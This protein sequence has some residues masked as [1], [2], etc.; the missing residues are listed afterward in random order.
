[1]S[2]LDLTTVNGVR[3]YLSSHEHLV[4]T[5]ILPLS[6]GTA[7]YAYRLNLE[8][9]YQGQL[10][11]VLKY[12]APYIPNHIDFAFDVIRQKYEVEALNLVRSWVSNAA[13]VNVPEVYHFDE[14]SGV[15][16][17]ED[18]GPSSKTLKEWVIQGELTTSL[19]EKLSRGLG[20]FLALIHERGTPEQ[21]SRFASNEQARSISIWATYGRLLSTLSGADGLP[22]LQEPPLEIDEETLE[23]VSDIVTK[24]STKLEVAQSQFV[25]GDFWPGNVLID[26]DEN[27]QIKKVLVVDWELAKAGIRGTDIGQ[28]CAELHLLRH[29]YPERK[30]ISTVLLKNFVDSY[31][32]KSPLG[33]DFREA[34]VHIGAHLI[35]WAP[36]VPWGPKREI[37]AVVVEG[38]KLLADES[39]ELRSFYT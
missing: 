8:S 37:Q 20:E 34:I 18:C 26:L 22:A 11:L 12:S 5:E 10:S 27:K 7:N 23:A 15:V 36:R 25:M 13:L 19:A 29:F 2:S 35:A 17:M 31:E 14:T 3:Q 32:Q 38:V 33:T 39:S 16:I 4:A 24:V 28:F 6:G 9:A 21:A 1:M 30:E